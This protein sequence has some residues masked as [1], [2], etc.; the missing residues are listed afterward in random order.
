MWGKLHSANF[1][2]R[3][4]FYDRFQA[5]WNTV[6][7]TRAVLVLPVPVPDH[8]TTRAVLVL[9]VPVTDYCITRA[10]LVLPVPVPDHS[11]TRAVLVLPVPVPD[12]RTT[13]CS[14]GQMQLSI[15]RPTNHTI[16]KA[17]IAVDCSSTRPVPRAVRCHISCKRLT[18]SHDPDRLQ[19][20][21]F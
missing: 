14:S 15:L 3:G 8:S 10:V 5:K 1:S 16:L 9:P 21:G 7:T 12:Y 4:R 13:R 17:T 6:Q 20:V 11:T 19:P 2:C 18:R